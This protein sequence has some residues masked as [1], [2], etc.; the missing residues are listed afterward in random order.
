M[1]ST[2]CVKTM[3]ERLSRLLLRIGAMLSVIWQ[4][5]GVTGG[6]LRVESGGGEDSGCAWC[7]VIVC[8]KRWNSGVISYAT[9][10]C[11][12]IIRYFTAV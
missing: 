2:L 11:Q 7:K 6:A 5:G 12:Y 9:H 4:R 10:Y 1:M 8:S 3:S